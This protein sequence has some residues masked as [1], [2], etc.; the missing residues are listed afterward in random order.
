MQFPNLWHPV[1]DVNRLREAYF[2]LN[3]RSAPGM[4]GQRWSEYGEKLEEN[5]KRFSGKLREGRCRATGGPTATVS[6]PCILPPLMSQEALDL[7][8]VKDPKDVAP[9][10]PGSAIAFLGS[11]LS[12]VGPSCDGVRAPLSA[13]AAPNL[14]SANRAGFGNVSEMSSAPDPRH[15]HFLRYFMASEPAVRAFVRSLVP[16]L[17]DSNDVMQEVAIVLWEKFTEYESSEDF[18]RWAFGVAKFKVLSWQRD[19][20]RDRYVFGLETTELLACE[21][22]RFSDHLEK[23][24]EVLRH[25]LQKLPIDQRTLVDSAYAPSVRIDELATRIGLSAMALY[26]KLHRIRMLLVECTHRELSH[27]RNL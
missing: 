23:Q 8:L 7:F 5:L 10:Q 2:G 14:L 21:V 22:D 18:R 13:S 26:K 4:D 3:P 9:S 1:D 24:R 19:R 15:Q 20:M 25:C 17:A 6:V 27:G 16:T 12:F 11:R